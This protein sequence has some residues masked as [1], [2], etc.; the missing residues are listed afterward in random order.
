MKAFSFLGDMIFA[1][2]RGSLVGLND[3]LLTKYLALYHGLPWT[4]SGWLLAAWA[5]CGASR[6]FKKSW[7]ATKSAP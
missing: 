1:L 7:L 6:N 2:V 4:T 5:A 3:F